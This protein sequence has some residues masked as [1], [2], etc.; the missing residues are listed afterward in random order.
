[1]AITREVGD[2][3]GESKLLSNL[4][5]V[6]AA[7]GDYPQAI[8]L[9]QRSLEMKRERG[10]RPG[11]SATLINLGAAYLRIGQYKRAIDLGQQALVIVR[12]LGDREGEVSALNNLGVIDR[13]RGFYAKATDWFQQS[14]AL[15]T[16]L[17]S[18]AGELVALVNLGAVAFSV[19]DYVQ[20]IAYQ[21]Q[22][23]TL[24]QQ[25]GDKAGEISA[26][27]NLG[28]SYEA[29]GQAEK[30][31]A[32]YQPSLAIAQA[33][34]DRIGQGKLLTNLGNAHY[35][36]DRYEAA[37]D[38]HQQSLGLK[39]AI[40]DR[41]GE[42]SSL[43][44]L[45]VISEKLGQSDRAI[46]QYRES[47]AIAREIGDRRGE[48]K[49]LNNLG[50]LYH[51][52]GQLDRAIPLLEDGVAIAQEIGDRSGAGA[53]LNNLGAALRDAG[54]LS[55]AES[56]LEEAIEVWEDLRAGLGQ[57]DDFKV[58]I[59][60]EQSLTYRL[61]QQV[62]IA[63]EKPEKALEIAERGR[64]RAFAERL[65]TRLVATA[66]D[67][68]AV[69]LPKLESP[70]VGE[71]R[72]IA[73][74]RNATLV[75]Y[76]L[77]PQD[78][79]LYIWVIQPTGEITFRSNDLPEIPLAELVTT[80][81]NAI[82]VR[83]RGL[84]V[85]ESGDEL[86]QTRQQQNLSQLHQLLIAP[87]ADLLPKDPTAQ[88]IFIPQQTLFL[89]PFP[90]LQDEAGQYLI[91]KHAILTAPSIQVL[92]FTQQRREQLERRQDIATNSA[93]VVGNPKMPSLPP[94]IGEPPQPLA[95]LPGAQVEAHIIADLLGTEALI[96]EAATKAAVL[97]E[98]PEARI[99]HLATH[100]LLDDF[101]VT[102]IPG[103]IAL[104]PSGEDSGFLTAAE[105]LDLQIQADLV[106]LSACNTGQGKIQWDGVIGLSRAFITA[107][108][109][110]VIVSLWQVPDAPT[111][112]LMTAFYE[113]LQ[114]QETPDKAQA[115]RQA[116]LSTREQYPNPRD[117]AAFTL[118]GE[119]Q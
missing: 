12:E 7:Q 97:E 34:G 11:E 58:S 73:R 77:S 92:D 41:P 101:N 20:A 62:A 10:D 25:L 81:R 79:R 57:Q 95:A 26:L 94:A 23:L 2:T 51:S 4:G 113:Q 86:G 82:G 13:D 90:A 22:A 110:S 85:V 19:G 69:D 107:G 45:G 112:A 18:P 108:T 114:Q 50:Y 70:S 39:Q 115:L 67:P 119:A 14:R 65:A 54:E 38:F 43:G 99:I 83:S 76:S 100:G 72:R 106:V 63:Q 36:L 74:D 75:E 91:E 98:L 32:F 96:G 44:S 17:G 48:S 1:M 47:L 111:A 56:V 24:A 35:L 84:G 104:A 87:I 27:S 105:V 31:L 3:V 66:A 6:Y 42:G 33:I 53:G 116:M 71:I 52:L 59:F 60:E 109:P 49:T 46:A 16:E 9:Y 78:Q 102:G 88:V 29:L 30:A 40:G 5:A 118:I 8:D 93:L 117:W 37:R 68:T 55:R 21:Q 64:A 15:A 80:S 89:V 28:T 103:A 61:L